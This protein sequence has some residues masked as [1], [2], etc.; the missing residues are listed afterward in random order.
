MVDTVE[1]QWF[2]QLWDMEV[3]SRHEH[4]MPVMVNSYRS[5]GKWE[6]FKDLFSIFHKIMVCCVFI[7]VALLRVS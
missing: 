7:R 2:E 6:R 4:F 3:C 1:L 5:V